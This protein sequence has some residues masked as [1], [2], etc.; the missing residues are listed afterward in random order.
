MFVESPSEGFLDQCTKDQLVKIIEY[1]RV[2]IDDENDKETVKPKWKT[3]LFKMEV[4][5]TAE[6]TSKLD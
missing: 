3:S 4:F 2:D 1:Y 6:A 5:G